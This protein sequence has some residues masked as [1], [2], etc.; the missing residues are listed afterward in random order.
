MP[1]ISPTAHELKCGPAMIGIGARN[2]H[3]MKPKRNAPSDVAPVS[4][5]TSVPV[6][7]AAARRTSGRTMKCRASSGAAPKIEIAAAASQ[8][9]PQ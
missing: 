8:A 3:A 1:K 2:R 4:R 6:I 7:A 9:S 5:R